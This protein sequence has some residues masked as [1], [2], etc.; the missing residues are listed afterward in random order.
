MFCQYFHLNEI[1]FNINCLHTKTIPSYVII[2]SHSNIENLISEILLHYFYNIYP[3]L[4]R[5]VTATFTVYLV[6]LLLHI[7]CLTRIGDDVS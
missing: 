2:I 7:I 3:S 4:K 1:F 5:F 6:L